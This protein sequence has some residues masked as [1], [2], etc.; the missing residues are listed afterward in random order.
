M[1]YMTNE[2]WLEAVR[3]NFDEALQMGDMHLAKDIIAD[4][5]DAGFKETARAMSLELRT[6][7]TYVNY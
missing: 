5:F 4:T 2:E 1:V 6:V 3:D 7:H